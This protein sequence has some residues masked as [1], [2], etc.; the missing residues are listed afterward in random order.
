L[1]IPTSS[2]G[3]F[4]RIG[5]LLSGYPSEEHNGFIKEVNAAFHKH[6]IPQGL[7]EDV[8]EDCYYTVT[9]V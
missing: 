9:L 4:R 6:D 3:E 8:D 1:V 5:L 2:A 7:Y